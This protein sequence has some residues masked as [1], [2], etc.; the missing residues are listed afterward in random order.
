MTAWFLERYPPANAVLLLAVA[1]VAHAFGHGG[2]APSALSAF[3]GLWC[4]YLLVRIVDE[5]KDYEADLAAHPERVLQSG[6]VTLGRLRLVAVG[7][8]AVQAAVTL[9]AG[10]AASGWWLILLGWLCWAAQ[11]FFTGGRLEGRPL[12]YPLAHVP[13]SGLAC[14]W[15]AQLGAGE[16]PVGFR[17]W[18]V[19]AFGTLLALAV[20]L[21][22]KL[23]SGGDRSYTR[24]LGAFRAR[25]LLA[26]VLSALAGAGAAVVQPGVWKALA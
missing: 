25:A 10:K 6:R 15:V 5:H 1:V 18:R 12:L 17:A 16:S 21:A 19:F 23:G 9:P 2:L 22:R 24:V 26:V 14:V 4:F 20:D 13:L 7:A 11:D 8:L 3:A